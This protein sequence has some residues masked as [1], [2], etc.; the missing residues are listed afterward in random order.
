VKFL[1][2]ALISLLIV[3]LA[4]STGC[5][6]DTYV[7]ASVGNFG[8]TPV[9]TDTSGTPWTPGVTGTGTP[10]ITM[11]TGS[12][13]PCLLGSSE[14]CKLYETCMNNCIKNGGSPGECTKICCHAQCYNK[15]TPEEKV[16]CA[17]VCLK[18]LTSPTLAPLDTPDPLAPL[19]PPT[20]APL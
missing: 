7:N 12:E 3:L 9:P 13:S 11:T 16:E 20:L 1:I 19:V 14:I 8:E 17:N 18:G 2:P 10:V 4:L 15:R 6:H 5:T